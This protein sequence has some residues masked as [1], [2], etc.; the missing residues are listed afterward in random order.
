MSSA[1]MNNQELLLTLEGIKK[2]EDELDHL[3]TVKRQEVAERIKVAIS[4]GDI[5]ENAE[6]DE[7]KNDQAFIEGRILTLEGMLRVARVVADEDVTTDAVNVG[8]VVKVLDVEFDEE[9]EYSIVGSA[10]ADPM[11][12]KI[13]NESPLGR[14][15]IGHAVGEEVQVQAPDGTLTLKIL[16]IHK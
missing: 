1:K 7:A 9:V 13:S 15:M 6:Y 2:L 14:A 4:F 12:G 5:S 10:E 11:K 16:D 8:V 3:K